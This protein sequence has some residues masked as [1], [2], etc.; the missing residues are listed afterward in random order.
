MA[1]NVVN[2]KTIG[3]LRILIYN[4]NILERGT[5]SS[6]TLGYRFESF[7]R[8]KFHRKDKSEV[9]DMDCFVKSKIE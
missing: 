1:T 7:L 6:D 3:H 5:L 9:D 8:F 2:V 4:A